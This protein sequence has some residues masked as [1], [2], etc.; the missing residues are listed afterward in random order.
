MGQ[1]ATS[2]TGSTV[3]NTV[4]PAVLWPGDEVYVWG[5]AQA[6]G[7]APTP[8]QIQAPNDSN[9][10]MEAIT[11]GERSLAA[12]LAPRPGGGYPPGIAV[13]I[14]LS[15]NPGVMEIDVQ[16]A[17]MDADGVYQ[18]PTGSAV[19]K[20]TTWNGPTGPSNLYNAYVELEP[21]S[22]RFVTLKCITNPN[23]V[24]ATAKISYV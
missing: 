12:A 6:A 15:A 14:T 18:T 23:G 13:L 7:A 2:G 9:V 19:Y 24:K 10:V 17:P 5:T 16:N 1:Y 20:I 3:L 4:L 8:G 11:V 22:D 21:E